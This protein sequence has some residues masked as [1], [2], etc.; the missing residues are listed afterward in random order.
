M[1]TMNSEVV[2]YQPD[3]ERARDAY[4]RHLMGETWDEI[5][6]DMGYASGNS[7]ASTVRVTLQKAALNLGQ[8][9]LDEILQ[10]DLDT[11]MLLQKALMPAAVMGDTKSVDSVLRVLDKRHKLLGFDK[12]EEKVTNQTLVVTSDNFID[13]LK[14][15]VEDRDGKP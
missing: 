1:T 12:R 11:L 5:A 2:E 4:Y 15:A 8:D 7:L 10:A 14:K 6:L 13:V 9:I 3:G